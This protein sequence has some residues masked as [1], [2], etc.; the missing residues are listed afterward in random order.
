MKTYVKALLLQGVVC[1]LLSFGAFLIRP[2]PV[3]YRICVWGV[4]PLSGSVSAF[5]VTRKGVN[6]Y[7]SW[8]LPPL[9]LTLGAWT[10][11]LW[12][13]LPNGGIM[14]LD[15]LLSLIGAAAGDVMQKGKA[16]RK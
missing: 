5:L 7:L 13:Y 2:L 10:A 8:I 1:L 14:L 9:M 3:L 15:A 11:N 4:L 12:L 6:P 16:K